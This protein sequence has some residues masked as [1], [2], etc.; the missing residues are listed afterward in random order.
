MYMCGSGS[1]FH[2]LSSE[3]IFKLE[4]NGKQSLLD[5]IPVIR[6]M[7]SLITFFPWHSDTNA[8]HPH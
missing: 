1:S 7:Q 8:K 3:Y 6:I 4:Q 5:S 2:S